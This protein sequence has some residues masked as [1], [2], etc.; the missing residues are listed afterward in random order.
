VL[1]RLLGRLP[2]AAGLGDTAAPLGG[3]VSKLVETRSDA[4]TEPQ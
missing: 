1:K 4:H 3:N 2:A